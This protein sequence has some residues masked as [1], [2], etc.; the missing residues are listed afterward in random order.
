[1]DQILL[2]L[3][4]RGNIG[5]ILTDIDISKDF[6]QMIP[7]AQETILK[8]DKQDYMKLKP[9]FTANKAIPRIVIPKHRYNNQTFD[10]YMTCR[11]LI[12]GKYKELQKLNTE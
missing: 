6:L 1:M 12:S 10:N 3:Y 2:D 8:L 5:K 11:Q 9:F 4:A 7:T